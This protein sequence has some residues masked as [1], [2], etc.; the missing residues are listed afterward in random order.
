MTD[1][2]PTPEPED[3]LAAAERILKDA[4]SDI[5]EGTFLDEDADGRDD[6]RTDEAGA[7]DALDAAER[8]AAEHL[9]DLQ[10]LQAEYVNYRKRVDRDRELITSN[11]TAKAVEALIPVLDDIAAAREHGDL[12]DGPFAS[13]ADKLETAL[14]R[15]G[16][17]SFG[18]VGEVFDPVHHE[19]L[20]SQPSTDVTEPTI[21]TVAQPGHR[22]GDRVVRPARVIVAQPEDQA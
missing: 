11:A 16:W 10:R 3:P 7:D 21:L 18:A 13:I 9:A 12:A 1:Q 5:P 19:A 2:N 6:L 20:L 22:I 15:L 17:S 8:K 4:A 14:G